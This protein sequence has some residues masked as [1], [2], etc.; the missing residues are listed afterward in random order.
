MLHCLHGYVVATLL[1]IYVFEKHIH[2]S[3]VQGEFSIGVSE[4]KT[5]QQ[6]A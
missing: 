3:E 2:A 6:S 5:S 1:R 4:W